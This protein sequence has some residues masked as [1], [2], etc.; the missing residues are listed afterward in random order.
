MP[1]RETR[2]NTPDSKMGGT[3]LMLL[4][5]F[6]LAIMAIIAAHNPDRRFHFQEGTCAEK[7][8]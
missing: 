5:L 7:C 8:R 2:D 1:K 6:G 4:I 3:I